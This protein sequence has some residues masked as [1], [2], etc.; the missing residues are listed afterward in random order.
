MLNGLVYLVY[1][2]YPHSTDHLGPSGVYIALMLYYKL[3]DILTAGG[4]AEGVP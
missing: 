4:L 1:G 3:R 2:V